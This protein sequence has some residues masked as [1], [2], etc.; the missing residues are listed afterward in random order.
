[1]LFSLLYCFEFPR[2][3]FVTVD[4]FLYKSMTCA[5]AGSKTAYRKCA[6]DPKGGKDAYGEG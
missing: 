3:S 5:A 1:M 6:H 4:E 2:H